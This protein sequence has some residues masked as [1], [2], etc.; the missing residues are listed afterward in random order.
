MLAYLCLGA[1]GEDL[2]GGQRKTMKQQRQALPSPGRFELPGAERGG[3]G[4]ASTL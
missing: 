3:H 1:N 4:E 2:S